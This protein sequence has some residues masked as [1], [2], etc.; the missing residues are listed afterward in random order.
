MTFDVAGARRA[1]YSDDEI[2]EFLARERSFDLSAARKSGYSSAEVLNHLLNPAKQTTQS[3]PASEAPAPID[4]TAAATEMQASTVA[5]AP[6]PRGQSVLDR[7]DT[8]DRTQDVGF[9]LRPEFVER[10]RNDFAKVPADKRREALIAAASGENGVNT[11]VS[12]AA[13]RILA[14][15]KAEDAMLQRES[16]LRRGTIDLLVNAPPGQPAAPKRGSAPPPAP[17]V[18]FPDM[19]PTFSETLDMLPEQERVQQRLRRDDITRGVVAAE[20]GLPAIADRAD[21]AARDYEA[22]AFAQNNPKLA[23]F[24]AGAGQNLAGLLNAVPTMMDFATRLVDKDATR[25]DNAPGVDSILRTARSYLPKQAQ[26][27]ITKAWEKGEFGEWLGYNLLAQAPQMVNHV[28]AAMV[29]ATRPFILPAM[30]ALSAGQS[31]A[32]GDSSLAAVLKGGAEIAGEKVTLGL[33]DRTYAALSR[34]PL[35]L[36]A[37]TVREVGKRLAAFGGAVTA[38]HLA[39]SIEEATTQILQNGVDRFVEGK[40]TGLLDKV[41]DA[42]VLGAFMEGP[43]AV[44]QAVRAFQSGT[45][46][47]NEALQGDIASTRAADTDPYARALLDPQNYQ[48]GT[49]RP[50]QTVRA[51]GGVGPPAPPRTDAGLV[52]GAAIEPL[53]PTPPDL[54][55][56]ADAALDNIR[57][58]ATIDDAVGNLDA[59]AG[60]GMLDTLTP[61]APPPSATPTLGL[62]DPTLEAQ[63]GLDALRGLNPALPTTPAP[64]PASEQTTAAA[65]AAAPAITA[66]RPTTIRGTPVVQLT[67]D[68]LQQIVGDETAPPISRRSASIELTARQTQAPEL[69]QT[70]TTASLMAPFAGTQG[71]PSATIQDTGSAAQTTGTTSVALNTPAGGVGLPDTSTGMLGGDPATADAR[72]RAQRTLDRWATETKQATPIKLGTATPEEET[73]VNQIAQ[74][75]GSQFGSEGGGQ[76]FAFSDPKSGVEGLTVSGMAF[77]NTAAPKINSAKTALHEFKHVVEQIADAETKAGMTGTAAQQ[78]TQ[79]IESIFDDISDPGKRAYVERFL[80][81]EELDAIFNPKTGKGTGT[82]A[83]RE[84]RLA[85]LVAAPTT[86][87]EMTADFLGNRAPDKQFWRDLAQQDPQGFTGFVQKWI[88]IVDNLLAKLKGNKGQ[89]RDESARVDTYVKDLQKAKM[90]AREALIAYS[91]STRAETAAAQGQQTT[92]AQTSA[93]APTG[94]ALALAQSNNTFTGQ[95]LGAGRSVGMTQPKGTP[96]EKLFSNFGDMRL[97]KN[98]VDQTGQKRTREQVEAQNSERFREGMFAR[99]NK[100]PQQFAMDPLS[101]QTFDLGDGVSVQLDAAK[102][103]NTRV[104]MRVGGDVV[105]AAGIQKGMVDAIAVPERFKGQ[106]Y[107]AKLLG[108]VNDNG[109]ANIEEV[110]DRSPGFVAIQ[111]KVLSEARGEQSTAEESTSAPQFSKAR[112]EDLTP[113][114]FTEQITYTGWQNTQP[115]EVPVVPASRNL[116]RMVDR[117]DSGQMSSAEFEMGVRML[118]GRMAN[119]ADAKQHNRSM[120]ERERGADLVREKLLAARRRGD[121]DPDTTEFALWALDQ[122]PALAI[123]LGFS[124][125]T[126]PEDAKGSAG[127]YNPLNEVARVFKGSANQGTAVHEILHHSERMMPRAVQQGVSREWSKAYSK[128]L[129]NATGPQREALRR[130]LD[131]LAGSTI[132]QREVRQAFRD[133]VLDADKHYQ[134]TNPSEYWA[135]NATRILNDRFMRSE[136]WVGRARQWL[137][138]MLQKAKGLFGL[139]S[140]APV[141][142]GLGAVLSGDGSFQSQTMLSEA[143]QYNSLVR[144]AEPDETEISTQNPQAVNRLYN[145]IDDML[146]IDEAAVREAMAL[147]VKSGKTPLAESITN[148]ILGYGFV[149]R[150]TP[151]DQ[152]IE[153]YKQSIVSNLMYLFGKVPK[154]IRERSKLW[155]DGAHRIATDMGKVYGV[156][157]EQVAGIMAAMSPQKDWFQNVSM[158]ERALDILTGQG[159]KAW[160]DNML[161]YAKSYVEETRDRKEREKRQKAYDRA[162]AVA[163]AGTVL[164]DMNADD[165]AVFIRSYDEAYHSRQYRIVTPEGGFGDLVRN[166]DGTPSTMMWST[167]DPI[168]KSVSIFRDGSRKNISEQ[169]GEEH[170]IRSFYNNIAAPNSPISHVTIDTHAVAAGHFEALAGTDKEVTD[171]FGGTGGSSLL[172]VGG[173]YGI[174]ADAYR[175]AAQMA[176]VSAREMQSITWEAVRGLFGE[177]IKSSIKPKV[178]NVW[179]QFRDGKLSFAAARRAIVKIAEGYNKTKG[180]ILNPD[181]VGSGP[182][183][184]VADGGTSYDKSFVPEGGVRLRES[185]ELREKVTINLSAATSSIPGLKELYARALEGEAKATQLLQQVAESSLRFLLGGTKARLVV[186]PS[187]GVYMSDREPSISIQVAFD[188]SESKPVLAALAAFADSYNQQQIHVRVPTIQVAG[189]EFGDGSY[190]TPVYEIDLRQELTPADISAIIEDSGLA[191]FTVTPETLTAYWVKPTDGA[192]HADDF[193]TFRARIARVQALVGQGNSRPKQRVERLYAYGEG[194][195]ARVPYSAIRGDVRTKAEADLETPRLIAE[196]LNKGPVRTF[197][198]KPLTAAQTKEQKQLAQI[199]EALP[200]NDLQRPIVRQ[201]YDA[202]AS[203]LKEQFQVLPIKV[204][205]MASVEID[206]KAYPYW[207]PKAQTLVGKL[208]D[209]GMTAEQARR[210]LQYLQRNYG[211]PSKSWKSGPLSKVKAMDGEP[212]ANSAEMRRDVSVNNRFRVYKTAPATFGPPGSDFSAHPLLQDSG[213]KDANGYPMLYNDLL[214]AVHDYFAHNLS[215]TQFGPTGE[216]AAWRN[217]MASTQDPMAR[218]ALTAETRLQNAWQNFRPGA[219]KLTVAERGFAEQKAALPPVQFTLTGDAQVD[220]P[221]QAFIKSLPEENL[222]GSLPP[223]VKIKGLSFGSTPQFSAARKDSQPDLSIAQLQGRQVSMPVR[224]EDTGETGTLTMDAGDSLADINEREAAMQRL[225]ECL[226][227]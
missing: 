52:S 226:R 68:A 188:E 157:M 209:E 227:K 117:L 127:D 86:R 90:V 25:Y 36:Q 23:A 149:P 130:M 60:T 40:N 55:A 85:E 64:A 208:V 26:Q 6:A 160:D 3:E 146:S 167:Y 27:D 223:D 199:F 107:G 34:L 102:A 42:A 156:K 125:R 225:L 161:A 221:M 82:Q 69:R 32:D 202:L 73:A 147:P 105:A 204:E 79:Q 179:S 118:A 196:Y 41:L 190:A 184:A 104:Q 203:A 150:D 192:Q 166:A 182:G 47:F 46:A 121:V 110:P 59:A 145:P 142:R 2:A 115:R 215:A 20:T 9:M 201:A 17:R 38:Q 100:N 176:G 180:G 43:L 152:V 163:N 81:K 222:R 124:V 13:Q 14:E 15:V 58:A 62:A 4:Y 57:N 45:S 78:F 140:D 218:W 108:W 185:K 76:I 122:N 10:V 162:V 126:A 116:N 191:G 21:R 70:A 106:E 49:I 172:G 220:A 1:G 138:E 212:Y 48:P 210:A 134:L 119:A 65:A 63:Y 112:T 24:A 170:K 120:R 159:N 67:D 197:A 216:A 217:H 39:G 206:G 61:P 50:Q 136:S 88:G 83:D 211:A 123:N 71:T 141:L 200:S 164:N 98:W 54:T 37:P 12:L 80:H 144:Q 148:A 16:L 33:F 165:A 177:N 31:F 35:S 186:A 195:G 219:E 109:V 114:P 87:K 18:N 66:P 171:N 193:K 178:R 205:V 187:T 94:S 77:V 198:Q 72:A 143:A 151:R 207:G 154:N 113:A 7:P 129:K 137:G 128:A 139:R 95:A 135:V 92:A 213:L 84:A 19:T 101:T 75:L 189:H 181:W 183:Q 175:T 53:T 22:E 153:V 56:R 97:P 131:A 155:Y 169:L 93:A 5:A 89:N 51:A 224:V 214:R 91:K 8:R 133:G 158:A 103:G 168:V 111:K 96:V 29:P 132:A 194:D 74:A 174:V 11:Q 173:T 28:I 99:A 44:P 30:G